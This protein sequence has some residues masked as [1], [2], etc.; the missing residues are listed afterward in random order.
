VR[1]VKW[2]KEEGRRRIRIAR[3]DKWEMVKVIAGR[4]V[5][6]TGKHGGTGAGKRS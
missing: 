4:K 5:K 2:T 3:R 1:R 6:A